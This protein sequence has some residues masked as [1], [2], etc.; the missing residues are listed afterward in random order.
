MSPDYT[1]SQTTFFLSMLSNL[2][3]HAERHRR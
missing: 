2:A 1:Q 3:D